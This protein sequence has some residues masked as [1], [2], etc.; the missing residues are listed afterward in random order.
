MIFFV[1]KWLLLRRLLTLKKL[2]KKV[3]ILSN[4]EI[5]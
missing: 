5:L 3:I 4:R 1:N 2:S